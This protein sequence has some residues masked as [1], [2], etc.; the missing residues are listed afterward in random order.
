[1]SVV[2]LKKVIAFVLENW[3]IFA[4]LGLA[5]G[6]FLYWNHRT[7]LI[8]DQQKQLKTLIESKATLEERCRL[9]KKGLIDQITTQNAAIEEFN[10]KNALNNQKVD[11]ARVEV[12]RIQQKYTDD[13]R[14]VLTGSKPG[15][16]SDAIKYLVDA[17]QEVN[18]PGVN[19]K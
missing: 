4:V 10:K 2:F 1:M 15:D 12:I 3:Q 11:Q 14:K 8:E 19:S 6:I 5:V 17:A 13:I 18:A 9:E 16:C 7:N